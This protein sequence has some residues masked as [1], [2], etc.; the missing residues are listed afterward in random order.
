MRGPARGSGSSHQY[1]NE[2]QKRND[3]QQ[4]G[5]TRPPPDRYCMKEKKRRGA[6]DNQVEHG[7]IK[8]CVRK[9]RANGLDETPMRKEALRCGG[10]EARL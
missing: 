1:W 6:G 7:V 2:W 4:P 5:S 9:G 10:S 3:F 8:T